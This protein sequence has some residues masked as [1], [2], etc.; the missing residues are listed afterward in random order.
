MAAE[1][2]PLRVTTS[3]TA[4]PAMKARL[5]RAA[6]IEGTSQTEIILRALNTYFERLDR[7]AWGTVDSEDHYDPTRFY[8]YGS[9]KHGHSSEIRVH[10]PKSLMGELSRLVESQQIPEYQRPVHI[11]RDGLYHRVK[12]L[13]RMLDDGELDRAVNMAILLS[14]EEA[15]KAET[16]EARSLIDAVRSNCQDLYDQGDIERLREYLS[17]RAGKA[18]AVPQ[19]FRPEYEG[20]LKDYRNR[21]RNR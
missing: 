12:Q 15:M 4:T 17:D 8:T 20:V 11:L 6:T 2:T 10:L 13:S 7:R 16:A 5:E 1:P 14:E 21:I 19:R 3:F 18:D 9:D